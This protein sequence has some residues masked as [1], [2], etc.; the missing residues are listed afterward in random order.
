MKIGGFL[1]LVAALGSVAGGCAFSD[2]HVTL[3]PTVPNHL[4][5]GDQ[6]H[7]I[8]A[9]PFADERAN[10]E[11][12]GTQKNGYNAETALALCT[13]DP[14]TW[15][16]NLLGVQLR[17]AGFQVV[18]PGTTPTPNTLVVSGALLKFFVE[19]LIGFTAIT[20]ETDV[21][22]RLTVTSGS[23]LVADRTFFTKGV[24]SGQVAR[25]GNFETSAANAGQQIMDEMVAAII[26][27]ANRYPQ[28]G[29]S[30]AT[31]R[32][33]TAATTQERDRCDGCSQSW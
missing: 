32:V 1:F 21:Q 20:L 27:L 7:V 9:S 22:V 11:R 2:V 23:G 24:A 33:A 19:P 26:S 4:S 16:A 8:V 15:L 25:A 30:A 12:C 10:K 5:G 28:L 14:A 3:P 6:R 17:A 13:P 18:P 31:G 29:G